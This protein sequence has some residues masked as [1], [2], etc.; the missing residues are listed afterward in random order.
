MMISSQKDSRIIWLCVGNKNN[1]FQLTQETLKKCPYN[2]QKKISLWWASLS[3]S[4]FGSSD[5][6]RHIDHSIYYQYKLHHL[7]DVYCLKI[8]DL[9]SEGK[10]QGD[11]S[12]FDGNT[13][14]FLRWS[15]CPL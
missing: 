4:F 14:L 6:S 15:Y 9:P 1:V 5:L 12:S 3:F 10:I 13:R 11:E 7:P 2:T 8:K